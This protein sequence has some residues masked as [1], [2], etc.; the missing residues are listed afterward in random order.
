[1]GYVDF[2][3]FGIIKAT[4]FV[5]KRFSSKVFFPGIT[6]MLVFVAVFSTA[7]L[8]RVYAMEKIP[9]VWTPGS[10]LQEPASSF[11]VGQGFSAE[12]MNAAFKQVI[13]D[14]DEEYLLRNHHTIDPV[15]FIKAAFDSGLVS[16]AKVLAQTSPAAL[17]CF[18]DQ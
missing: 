14:K 6:K 11:E 3:K 16:V 7:L 15:P 8:S 12:S 1:M 9:G 10:G 5:L 4:M 2:P 18:L 13:E 17:E